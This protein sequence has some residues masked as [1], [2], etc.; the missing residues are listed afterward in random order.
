MW[1]IIDRERDGGQEEEMG[2]KRRE[3]EGMDVSNIMM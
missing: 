2:H 3:R 1:K